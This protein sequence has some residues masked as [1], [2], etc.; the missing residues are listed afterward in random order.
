M[1]HVNAWSKALEIVG[2]GISGAIRLYLV[3][4]F[5]MAVVV[6]KIMIFN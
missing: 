5:D 3:P 1:C 4:V 6:G 2:G